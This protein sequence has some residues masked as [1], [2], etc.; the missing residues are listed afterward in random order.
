MNT[1]VEL[2]SSL[3]PVDKALLHKVTGK[4]SL[5]ATGTEIIYF[6]FKKTKTKHCTDG[7]SYLKS[8]QS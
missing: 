1:L 8:I 7:L 2:S 5:K 6:L 3:Q 4:K